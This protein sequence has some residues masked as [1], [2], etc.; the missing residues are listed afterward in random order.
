L[1]GACR[2]PDPSTAGD[3]LRRFTPET[4]VALQGVIDANRAK[5]WR[6]LPRRRRRV[7]TLDMDSTI[8]EVFGEC[9]QGADFSYNGKWSYHPLL[10]TLAETHEPLRTI[11]RP[12]NTASADGAGPALQEVLPLLR[13]HFGQVRVRGD[14]KFY[15]REVIAAC[16]EHEAA[17]ALVMDHY[18]VLQE[19]AETL[20]N[21]AWQ[22]FYEQ[23][24]QEDTD[25]NSVKKNRH[26][27]RRW[28]QRIARQRGYT[29]LHTTNQWVAEFTYTLSPQAPDTAYG[30]NGRAYRVVVKRQRVE[31]SQGQKLLLSEDRYRFVITNIPPWEMDAAEV[32]RFAHGRGDQENAIEQLKNGIAALRMPTG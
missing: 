3:F 20:P 24:P 14:S 17:F 32:F 15:R 21:A 26:K 28:R 30:L 31:T 4:L 16:E 8:K 13:Q 1:L 6:Q 29:T 9:K 27:R 22:P 7:A 2:I 12:G 23:E 18:A 10:F 19:N 11:N 25:G 5:V